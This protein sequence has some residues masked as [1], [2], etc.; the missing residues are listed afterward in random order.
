[1][2][3]ILW[4]NLVDQSI[5]KK[6]AILD[7]IK[8]EIVDNTDLALYLLEIMDQNNKNILLKNTKYIIKIHLIFYKI[9]QKQEN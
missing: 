5:A 4:H 8:N 2:P 7:M 9:L 3:G 1:M 6:L